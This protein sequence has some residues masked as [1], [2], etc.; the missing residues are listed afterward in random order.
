MKKFRIDLHIHTVLSPCG[1]LEMSP[2]KIVNEAIKKKLDA[3]SITD[4]NTMRQ[5]NEVVKVGKEKGLIVICGVEIATREEAHCLA[6]FENNDEQA[7]FQQYLDE[8][9]PNLSYDPEKFGYQVWV[10]RNEEIMGE[11]LRYLLSGLNADIDEVAFKVKELNG[12]FIPAHIDR[13]R[14]SII[15]QLGFLNDDLPVD[16]IEISKHVDWKLLISKHP[17]LKNYTIISSSDAHT[18]EMIGTS[19]SIFEMETLTFDEIRKALRR[20]SGRKA[21]PENI[22]LI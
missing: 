11:E 1:S 12:L 21:Y 3:I 4:H 8:K 20:E 15:S 19:P 2:E 9:L 14:F 6:F 13:A 5:C 18:P 17:Y 16:A 10:N 7:A 22:K